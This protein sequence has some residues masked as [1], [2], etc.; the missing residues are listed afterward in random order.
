MP[1]P[2]DT[3][4]R[5]YLASQSPFPTRALG[6]RESTHSI[7]NT[8]VGVDSIQPEELAATQLAV[9][10]LPIQLQSQESAGQWFIE[11]VRLST[12]ISVAVFLK[13]N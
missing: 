11:S 9:P 13:Q 3:R 7:G 8:I 1:T 6:S 5:A 2:A 10:T 4:D 12:E